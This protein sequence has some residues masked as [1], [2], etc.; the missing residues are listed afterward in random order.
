MQEIYSTLHQNIQDA[1]NEDALEIASPHISAVRDGNPMNI[2]DDYL[3]KDYQPP[4]FRLFGL[5]GGGGVKE[6]P[7]GA[8]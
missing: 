4:A 7:A 1:F 6:G 2:P 5:G 3:P 8:S